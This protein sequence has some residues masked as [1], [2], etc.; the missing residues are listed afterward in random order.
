MKIQVNCNDTTIDCTTI[1]ELWDI[2]HP[3]ESNAE[4]AANQ[5]HKVAPPSAWNS[6]PLNDR[7]DKKGI[8]PSREKAQGFGMNFA[9]KSM[10]THCWQIDLGKDRDHAL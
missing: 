7:D 2:A 3:Q 5:T 9:A 4:Q 6:T 1:Q 8:A 10:L